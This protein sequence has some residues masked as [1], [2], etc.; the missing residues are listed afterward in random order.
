MEGSA[1]SW[2]RK[3]QEHYDKIALKYDERKESNYYL[4]VEEIVQEFVPSKRFVLDL[5]C[6]SGKLL[7]DLFLRGVG[8]D[9]SSK[10]ITF[11]RDKRTNHD[12]LV[13]DIKHLPFQGVQFPAVVCVDVL[14]HVND[15]EQLIEELKRITEI[16]GIVVIITANFFFWPLLELL[17]I[18]QLKLPEG[19][20]KWIRSQAVVGLLKE[21]GFQC[22]TTIHYFGLIQAIIAQKQSE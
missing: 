8:V 2:D 15:T 6:G 13:A 19:P 18:F 17:E 5:G 9:L 11:A 21:R 4:A 7:R 14:E 12:Y 22:N 1:I 3:I 20:H 10:L 16:G